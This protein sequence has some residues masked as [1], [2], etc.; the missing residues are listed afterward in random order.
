[1]VF[2]DDNNHPD[3]INY[4]KLCL[5]LVEIVR[6]HERKLNHD[7]PHLVKYI[8]NGDE[9]SDMSKDNHEEL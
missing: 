8:E 9:V 4:R 5:Y 6:E 1:L 2:Y 7:S 3:G